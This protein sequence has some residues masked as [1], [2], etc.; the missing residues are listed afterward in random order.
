MYFK[1]IF[2]VRFLIS[3][4]FKLEMSGRVDKSGAEK[5][6]KPERVFWKP[7]TLTD[8]A[9]GCLDWSSIS[10]ILWQFKV[11]THSF[12]GLKEFFNVKLVEWRIEGV[13]S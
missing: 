10:L 9:Q 13:M 6:K 5:L 2:S 7:N 3:V 1:N 11:L 12:K 8:T 4:E